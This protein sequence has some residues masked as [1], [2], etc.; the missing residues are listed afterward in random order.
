MG[1]I[2]YFKWL[3]SKRFILLILLSSVFLVSC[4]LNTVEFSEIK[5][6]LKA[7]YS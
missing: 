5:T 4:E 1:R 2:L 7:G 3:N 6:F